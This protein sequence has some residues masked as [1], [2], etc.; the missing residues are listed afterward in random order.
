MTAKAR[1]V[2]LYIGGDDVEVHIQRIGHRGRQQV[3]R[4]TL[5]RGEPSID[6]LWGLLRERK[7]TS[8]AAHMGWGVTSTNGRAHRI[9]TITESTDL[10]IETEAQNEEMLSRIE[11]LM[12]AAPGADRVAYLLKGAQE[13]Q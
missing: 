2:T 9:Y 10:H 8:Y 5:H 12:N 7:Y 6:R 1:F 3:G 4:Y 13:C 11:K